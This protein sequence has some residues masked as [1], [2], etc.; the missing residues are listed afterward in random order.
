MSNEKK[1]TNDDIG[2]PEMEPASPEPE[3]LERPKLKSPK[4]NAV[5]NRSGQI[6]RPPKI[7]ETQVSLIKYTGYCRFN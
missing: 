4:D 7:L 6:I 2:N 5:R 1:K 3:R